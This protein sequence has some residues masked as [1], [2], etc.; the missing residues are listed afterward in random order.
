MCTSLIIST[1]FFISTRISIQVFF[2]FKY[3]YCLLFFPLTTALGKRAPLVDEKC[4][5]KEH[6]SKKPIEE[7]EVK[8]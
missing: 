3:F 2:F 1:M 5:N 7:K 6:E 4:F 8:N